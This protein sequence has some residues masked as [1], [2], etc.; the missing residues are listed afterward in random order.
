[1]AF[2]RAEL[3][4]HTTGAGFG[5]AKTVTHPI[6]A[7]APAKRASKFLLAASVRISLSSVRSDTALLSRSF[8]LS[9]AF[10]RFS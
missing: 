10:R 6:D 7:V 9:S 3:S 2:C 5:D 8:S 1:M 4:E